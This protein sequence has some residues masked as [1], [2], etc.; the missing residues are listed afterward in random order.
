MLHGP[1][2]D[3]AFEEATDEAWEFWERKSDSTGLR[4]SGAFLLLFY[5]LA[6]GLGAVAVFYP[7]EL[8]TPTEDV[9]MIGHREHFKDLLF[10]MHF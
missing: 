10:D 5:L 7:A 9:K 1:T 3:E 4:L 2:A 6:V 8:A